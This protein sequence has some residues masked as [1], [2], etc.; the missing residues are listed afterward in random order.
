MREKKE[1][2]KIRELTLQVRELN[3]I[4]ERLIDQV[5]ALTKRDGRLAYENFELLETLREKD[6][7]IE[8][9]LN[10]L[11]DIQ[12]RAQ[13]V[14][15]MLPLMEREV[16]TTALDRVLERAI[17]L[18]VCK[19]NGDGTESLYIKTAELREIVEELKK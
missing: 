3:E 4:R 18:A 2:L 16:R 11:T 13:N 7:R 6:K 12:Q 14:R 5:V 19:D 10:C 1:Q 9:L 15:E 17:N 8:D